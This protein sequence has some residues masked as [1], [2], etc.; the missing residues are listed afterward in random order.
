M[1]QK[2]AWIQL[3]VGDA[4]LEVNV[5]GS[6]EPVVLIQTALTADEFVP[7]ASQPALGDAYRMILYHRRGYA[8]SSHVQGPGGRGRSSGTPTTATALLTALHLDRAHIVG[9]SYSAAV[10]LQLAATTPGRVHS[11]CLIEPPP[12]HIP[13]ADEFRAANARVAE[14]FRL[15]GP[16]TALDRS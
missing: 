8:G 9:V 7:L 12:V 4:T 10:A 6:G 15:Y 14:D 16:V 11:L 2:S 1:I 3:L 13:S 5:R